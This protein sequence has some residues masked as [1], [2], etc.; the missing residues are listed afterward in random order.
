MI[1]PARKNDS[2]ALLSRIEGGS[3]RAQAVAVH[4]DRRES[5]GM[6]Q[7]RTR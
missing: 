5:P 2:C 1:P 6:G 7:S 4:I 3:R